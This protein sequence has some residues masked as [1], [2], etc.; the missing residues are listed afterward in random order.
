MINLTP[1]LKE[2]INKIAKLHDFKESFDLQGHI[3]D[4]NSLLDGY[5]FFL[6]ALFDVNT[7]IPEKKN[8]I[9][10]LVNTL[11]EIITTL[12]IF[13]SEERK[14]LETISKTFCKDEIF[15]LQMPKLEADLKLLALSANALVSKPKR[16]K[17]K[18]PKS[19]LKPLI[20]RLAII[21]HMGTG[22]EPICDHHRTTEE[23]SGCFYEFLLDL[24]PILEE[25]GISLGHEGT[26]GK[27]AFDQTR[28]YK[29]LL[30]ETNIDIKALWEYDYSPSD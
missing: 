10:Q 26:T 5:Q 9:Q 15:S 28:N 2:K 17:R 21:F 20:L 7:V 3:A 23:F 14:E 30:M 29:R 1:C 13:T 19:R 22:K 6:N 16:D 25:I 18:L 4:I 12:S 8:G 27:Y 11:K 24:E